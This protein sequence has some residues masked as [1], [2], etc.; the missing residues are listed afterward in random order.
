MRPRRTTKLELSTL[1]A[2]SVISGR[3]FNK[4]NFDTVLLS[5]GPVHVTGISIKQFL[6][7]PDNLAGG[8]GAVFLPW[9]ALVDGLNRTR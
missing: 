5:V 8:L 9:P 3:V 7:R 6:L 2:F 4:A 1:K